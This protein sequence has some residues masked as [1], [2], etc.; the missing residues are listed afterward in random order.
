M[1]IDTESIELEDSTIQTLDKEISDYLS[2]RRYLSLK[3]E[4]SD[5]Y[6]EITP[7]KN[8]WLISTYYKM[9]LQDQ[10]SFNY[11]PESLKYFNKKSIEMLKEANTKIRSG[12]C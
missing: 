3:F 11:Y 6:I 2:M 9:E 10:E 1:G 5:W 4:I 12:E 8:R 7:Y